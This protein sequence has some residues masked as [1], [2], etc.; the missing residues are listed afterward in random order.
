MGDIQEV[1]F[2]KEKSLS[3]LFPNF[4]FVKNKNLC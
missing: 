3:E 1:S 2:L 4:S